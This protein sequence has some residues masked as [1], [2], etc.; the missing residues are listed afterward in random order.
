MLPLTPGHRHQHLVPARPFPFCPRPVGSPQPCSYRSFS[1][2]PQAQHL[3][4]AAVHV[5]PGG[6]APLQGGWMRFQERPA[7]KPAVHLSVLKCFQSFLLLVP[8]KPVLSSS[9]DARW[10]LSVLGVL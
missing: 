4:A 10:E 8:Q 6:T 2:A 7:A 3:A 9:E 1:P 5:V